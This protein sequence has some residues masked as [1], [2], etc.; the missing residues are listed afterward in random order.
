MNNNKLEYMTYTG[1]QWRYTSKNKG[2]AGYR[3]KVCRERG[4]NRRGCPYL[5]KE[6][7]SKT[8]KF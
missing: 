3:C 7:K 6:E 1:A 4:H 2:S 8:K 5:T